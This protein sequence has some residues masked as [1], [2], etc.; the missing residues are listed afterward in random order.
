MR[1]AVTIRAIAGGVLAAMA[2]LLC[3]CYHP[4]FV[5]SLHEFSD[6]QLKT[7][8]NHTVRDNNFLNPRTIRRFPFLHSRAFCGGEMYGP[9]KKGRYGLRLQVDRWNLD[10]M[11]QVAGNY[12]GMLYAVSIDGIYVGSSHF[13]RSMRDTPV[14][15]IEPIFTRNEAEKTIEYLQKNYEHFN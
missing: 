6:A 9:D 2:L 12:Y 7:N 13:N 11:K 15:E 8:L 5:L 10:A 1:S 14:C 3:S 4:A